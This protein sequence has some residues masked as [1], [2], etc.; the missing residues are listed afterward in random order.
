VLDRRSHTPRIG[1]VDPTAERMTITSHQHALATGTVLMEYR[2]TGLLGAGAF[3]IT[4]LARDT[5]LDKDVAIKEYLPSAFAARGAD[6][7]VVPVTHQQSED[8]RW[9]LERFSQ[10]ARTLARFSH[11]NIVRVIRY[12]ESN[13]TGYM[14][15]DYEHGE[16]LKAFAQ[17]HPFPTEG[18]LKAMIRPLLDGLE[19]VHAAGFLHRDIKP[20]NIFLREDGC[21]VLIDFG[22][23]RQTA[24]E[25]G[26]PLTT[27]LTPG[28]APFEQYT[29]S[30]KQGPWS[31]IYSLGGVLYFLVVGRNP[32]DAIARMKGDTLPEQL[33]GALDRYSP[34]L[35]EAIGWSLAIEET[36]RPADVAGWRNALLN[37]AEL[38]RDA[39][40]AS[41]GVR[42]SRVEPYVR[43]DVLPSVT[44]PLAPIP[45]TEIPP[46]TV[47]VPVEPPDT[48]V[49]AAPVFWSSN[50]LFADL[51]LVI[52]CAVLG[53]WLVRLPAFQETQIVQSK[54][55]AV[56]ITQFL[57]TA[58]VVTFLWLFGRGVAL[59]FRSRGG[60]QSVLCDLLTPIVTLLALAIAYVLLQRPIAPL[61]DESWSSVYARAFLLATCACA[62]W[63]SM[64]VFTHAEPLRRLR[65]E[66]RAATRKVRPDNSV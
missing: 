13:G 21:P 5:H 35:I 59:R 49:L 63:L 12:F 53:F 60:P 2:L 48:Q 26:Q 27:I 62:V 15:M 55:G 43:T 10:E 19:K 38:D 11:P 34:A 32:P 22:S 56:A 23:A 58:G 52:V 42:A 28:Y 6:G 66:Y 3:G 37:A 39:T 4:Y 24:G 17:K 29:T 61:L 33:A 64:V 31:D 40:P 18:T 44:Q 16:P 8:Y 47:R 50:R 1:Q 36:S 51:L 30:K 25:S 20:D 57:S 14:V 45:L 7:T 46:T 9:G 41:V 65:Q 54:A